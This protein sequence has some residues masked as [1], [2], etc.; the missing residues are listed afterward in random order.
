VVGGGDV[1][2]GGPGTFAVHAAGA[3][4]VVVVAARGAVVVVNAAEI[5]VVVVDAAAVV[6]GKGAV[7]A[8]V[9]TGDADDVELLPGT[10]VWALAG[11]R[12]KPANNNVVTTHTMTARPR[13]G[14]EASGGR[15]GDIIL[16]CEVGVTSEP[17]G[18]R[19]SR[20]DGSATAA[21]RGAARR[22]AWVRGSSAALARGGWRAHSRSTAVGSVP[23]CHCGGRR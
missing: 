18:S 4:A 3:T 19:R 9:V 20:R 17:D 10:V 15:L 21:R 22:W 6:D 12:A 14:G 1:G 7:V 13:W 11:G 16:G 2:G 5:V 8:A 23:P